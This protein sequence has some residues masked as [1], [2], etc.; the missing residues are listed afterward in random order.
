M[1]PLVEAVKT[2]ASV[3]ELCD[4]FREEFGEYQPA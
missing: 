4:V 3:G 1:Y 2:Y